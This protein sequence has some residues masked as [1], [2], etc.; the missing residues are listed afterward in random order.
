MPRRKIRKTRKV[1]KKK[2]GYSK[3]RKKRT[4]ATSWHKHASEVAARRRRAD[5]RKHGSLSAARK[6]RKARAE[7]D[8]DARKANESDWRKAF[9]AR[10]GRTPSDFDWMSDFNYT[11]RERYETAEPSHGRA[12]T[13]T[14]VEDR[15]SRILAKLRTLANDSRTPAGERAAARARIA[16]ILGR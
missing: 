14:S 3:S 6:E 10:H 15:R 11:W 5:V 16:E 13:A 12:S 8:W 7:R 9:V 4:Y 1:R 2:R